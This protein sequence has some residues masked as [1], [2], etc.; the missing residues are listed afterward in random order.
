MV[1]KKSANPVLFLSCL[2]VAYALIVVGIDKA[3]GSAAA[4]PAGVALTALATTIATKYRSVFSDDARSGEDDRKVGPKWALI[5]FA[6]FAFNGIQLLTGFLDAL[7]HGFFPV[8]PLVG[9]SVASLK[10]DIPFMVFSYAVAGALMAAALPAIRNSTV[11]WSAFV[12]YIFNVLIE[13]TSVAVSQ[14]RGIPQTLQATLKASAPLQF[15]SLLY[16]AAAVGA[17]VL[18]HRVRKT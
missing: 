12:S 13:L 1:P 7:I 15:F 4:G 9:A 5:V 8:F 18:V 6:M 14:G 10:F 17:S 16:V 2:G 11:A 3:F